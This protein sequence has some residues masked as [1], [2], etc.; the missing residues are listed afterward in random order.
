MKKF[1]DKKHHNSSIEIILILNK[2]TN[3]LCMTKVAE[4]N[5][6]TFLMEFNEKVCFF[7]EYILKTF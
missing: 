6:V 5:V 7:F 1:R 4:F 2:F 3:K